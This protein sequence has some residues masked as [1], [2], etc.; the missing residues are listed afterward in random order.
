[1]NT[2]ITELSK[3][4]EEWKRERE[5]DELMGKKKSENRKAMDDLTEKVYERAIAERKRK[6]AAMY[7]V[8]EFVDM[9]SEALYDFLNRTFGESQETEG[10]HHIEDIAAHASVFTEAMYATATNLYL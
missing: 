5:R 3:T 8:R 10:A 1:M 2:D 4:Y 6:A 7:T 9:H